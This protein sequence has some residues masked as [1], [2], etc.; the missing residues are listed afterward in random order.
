[1]DKVSQELISGLPWVAMRYR[2]RKGAS[3]RYG[4]SPSII[5][6]AMM[7][8]DQMSTFLSE[9]IGLSDDLDQ[10]YDFGNIFAAK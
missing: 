9:K 8:S 1:V 10:C 2:A 6:M 5:S 4:G 3:F 7:P